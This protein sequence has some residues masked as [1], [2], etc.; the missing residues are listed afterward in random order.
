ME[1][2]VEISGKQYLVK[3]GQTIK[4]ATQHAE[5]GA[6]I[7]FEKILFA[8]DGK[9]VWVEKVPVIVTA[10]V[11]SHGL[12]KKIRVFKHHAKKRYRRTQGHRQ[13]YT[14]IK[15]ETISKSK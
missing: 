11:V 7:K 3:A 8:N 4:V 10:S 5:V 2:V 1:A 6:E 13:A 9:N 12:N 14:E 15:I